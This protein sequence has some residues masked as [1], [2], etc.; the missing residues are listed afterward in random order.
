MKRQEKR[1]M[2]RK[3]EALT[4]K[5]D[6]AR[7]LAV[8]GPVTTDQVLTA[9]G[10]AGSGRFGINSVAKLYAV[11][12]LQSGLSGAIDWTEI[13]KAIITRWGPGGLDFLKRKA[14]GEIK[15]ARPPL[16]PPGPADPPGRV[17]VRRHAPIVSRAVFVLVWG[18]IVFMGGSVAAWIL[19]FAWK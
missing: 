14:W 18:A 17:F 10:A 1:E 12:V 19:Y 7:I 15:A 6:P 4:A 5:A 11:A 13:G 8:D 2:R 9:I 16:D 3:L